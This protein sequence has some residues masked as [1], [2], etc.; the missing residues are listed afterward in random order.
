MDVLS[1]QVHCVLQISFPLPSPFTPSYRQ[2]NWEIG[3]EEFMRE[4][5]FVD[6][7]YDTKCNI[8]FFC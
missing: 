5:I 1:F 4:F 7:I 2:M 6:F 3:I 8:M